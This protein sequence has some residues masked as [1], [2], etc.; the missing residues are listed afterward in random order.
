MTQT[1]S[2][3]RIAGLRATYTIERELGE[4]GF[5]V[6]S[7]A[8]DEAGTRV[9][10]KQL[11]MAR[12]GEWKALELFEREARVLAALDHPNIPRCREFFATDGSRA[13]AASELAQLGAGASL[14][15]VQDHVEGSSLQA[16]IGARERMT[17]TQAEAILRELL[18]VLMYLHELHPPVIHRDIKPANVVVTPAGKPMLV[19]FGAIQDRSRG[20]SELGSTTVGT[21]G[22]FP[23]EQVLGK[24][25]PASDLY[26][27]AVTMV[28]ALSHRR[29]E[30]LP[31]DA[32]TSKV[33]VA[34]AC[35]GLPQRLA[36][37]L[38]RMLEPAIGQRIA[39]ARDAV[40]AL[41]GALEKVGSVAPVRKDRSLPALVWKVP[42][43]GGG[44]ITL[45]LY[46]VLFDSFSESDLVAF[47]F[48]WIPVLAFGL[49][50]RATDS[51]RGGIVWAGGSL[52]A[53]AVFLAVVFPLL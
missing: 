52:V 48:V 8:T 12:M 10:L 22:Y 6:A 47:S 9:V 31:I 1:S 4:G 53:L 43:W 19:D 17:A 40:R 20:E 25:R 39:S 32:A 46:G 44:I 36:G 3:R 45:A 51:V 26:A 34:E 27:L 15:L 13:V 41:D 7:L 29:P 30:E 37:T 16:R 11:H 42:L 28:V 14:V 2:N 18:A 33:I 50:A 38:D 21:F 5:G 24:A 49:G 35:P 23:I